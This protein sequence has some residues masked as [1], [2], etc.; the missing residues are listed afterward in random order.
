VAA[1]NGHLDVVKLLVDRGAQMN[2]QDV[3]LW[4]P[5]YFAAKNGHE[6]VVRFLA[7]AGAALDLKDNVS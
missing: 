7:E 4:S 1:T 3:D 2:V 6:L 5:L